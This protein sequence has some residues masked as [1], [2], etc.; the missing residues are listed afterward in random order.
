MFDLRL[1]M[2]GFAPLQTS[3]LTVTIGKVRSRLSLARKRHQL[4]SGTRFK[5]ERA[6]VSNSLAPNAA[7]MPRGAH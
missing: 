4:Q 5:T 2:A 6:A 1:A 7:A 3:M